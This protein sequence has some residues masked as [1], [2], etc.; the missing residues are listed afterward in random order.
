[1]LPTKKAPFVG[2]GT[3]TVNGSRNTPGVALKSP[4][5]SAAVGTYAVAYTPEASFTDPQN[6]WSA[7]LGAGSCERRSLYVLIDMFPITSRSPVT[8]L[9][10]T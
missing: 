10:E 2:P 1:M 3:V 7:K 4:F 9:P 5:H 8:L 6:S